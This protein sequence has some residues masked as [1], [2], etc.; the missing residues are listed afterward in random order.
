MLEYSTTTTTATTATTITVATATAAA[1]PTKTLSP[2]HH[3]PSP[4]RLQYLRLSYQSM[5]E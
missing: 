1:T 2:Y 5:P 4:V 3:Q